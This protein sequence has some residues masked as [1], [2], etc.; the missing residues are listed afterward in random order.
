MLKLIFIGFLNIS[1]LSEGNPCT[2]LFST[3][4]YDPD[5]IYDVKKSYQA[6]KDPNLSLIPE[7]GLLSLQKEIEKNGLFTVIPDSKPLNPNETGSYAR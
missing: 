6:L 1:V 7:P 5:Q 4:L 3:F 2:N